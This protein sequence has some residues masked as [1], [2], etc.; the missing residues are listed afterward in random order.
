M[1]SQLA[2]AQIVLVAL[3]KIALG[4]IAPL[5]LD[6]PRANAII[7]NCSHLIETLAWLCLCVH[8]VDRHPRP[9]PRKAPGPFPYLLVVV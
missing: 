9:N 6:A 3:A 4:L 7:S 1:L 8:P 5:V 2:F